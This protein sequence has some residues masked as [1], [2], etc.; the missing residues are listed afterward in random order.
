M[1]YIKG[2]VSR[3]HEKTGLK[4]QFYDFS[5]N[6]DAIAISD[7]LDIPKYLIRKNKMV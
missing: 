4:E 3:Q 5:V 7:I 1:K 6:Y 2:Q